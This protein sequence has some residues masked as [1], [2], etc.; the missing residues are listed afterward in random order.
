M[1]TG[2]RGR[3]NRY[4]P[5]FRRV[6]YI[7]NER[8]QA[9]P[10]RLIDDRGK[11]IGIVSREEALNLAKERGADL[12]LITTHAQP[13]VVKLIEFSKF[14]Y[15]ENKKQKEAKKGIKK[16][17]IKDIK[18]SL[19]IGKGDLER[20]TNKTRDF[21]SEGYQVRI[22]LVLRGRELGKK[23]MAFDLINQF[24][25]SL[26]DI[27]TISTPPKIQGRIIMAVVTKRK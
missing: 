11:Q 18:L 6:H 23:P 22:A 13:P 19:F 4:Q 10:I 9:S 27:A 20:L 15:Q 5:R 16:S 21:I 2:Y 3:F 25:K 26:E 24:I 1:K 17:I 12:I 8:I 7:L 14:L